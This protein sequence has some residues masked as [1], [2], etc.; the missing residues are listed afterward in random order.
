MH[1]ASPLEL[2]ANV[3]TEHSIKSFPFATFYQDQRIS[4]SEAAWGGDDH[5]SEE[6]LVL[7]EKNRARIEFP[8]DRPLLRDRATS[9]LTVLFRN[10]NARGIQEEA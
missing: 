2:T 3:L 1:N 8:R 5:G 9:H 4:E 10:L 6:Q 7:P